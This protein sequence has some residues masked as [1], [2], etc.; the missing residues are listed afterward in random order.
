MA[1]KSLSIREG[2]R[3][4]ALIK[5]PVLFEAIGIAPV[6]AM[7][8]SVK[9]AIML[10]VIS[11]IEFVLIESFT[12]FFLKQLKRWFRVL[13][14]AVLGVLIN[15]P[16]FL[17]FNKFAPNDTANVSI[18]LPLIAVNSMIA[19]HCERIAVKNDY[20]HTLVDAVSAS[21]G[22]VFIIFIVGTVREVLGS[23]TFYGNSLNLPVQL[24]GM[25]LPFGG[26]LLLGFIAAFAKKI[27]KKKYPE[28]NPELAF[29]LSE[30]AD[31]GIEN[32][33][34]FV[35]DEHNP[36]EDMFSS[37]ELENNGN[38]PF[39]QPEEAPEEYRR[40]KKDKKEKVKKEKSPRIRKQ[41]MS[42]EE[43]PLREQA[44]ISA[45]KEE[46]RA[47]ARESYVSE[48]DDILTELENVKKETK[49]TSDGAEVIDEIDALSEKYSIGDSEPEA[50]FDQSGE[51]GEE[52]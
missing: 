18:F 28:E 21:V 45:E 32:I 11:T 20:R 27:I 10:S 50:D 19:L 41:R 15:I 29:N 48:F 14:Y 16:L 17:F 31:K 33:A 23:G 40:A 44:E 4:S 37:G 25:V 47:P 26:F 38:E 12:C 9:T 43:E 6:V 30:I 7:A 1:E 35:L 36:F 39:V 24:S 52:K 13:V 42:K 2:V 46:K 34:S 8:V 22:Y 51:D 3:N 49:E 5:N